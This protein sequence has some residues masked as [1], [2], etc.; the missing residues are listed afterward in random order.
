MPNLV[1]LALMIPDKMIFKVQIFLS[2][3][4]TGL[5]EGSNSFKK[6]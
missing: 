1:A 5:L 2:F 3:V 4:A 6:F